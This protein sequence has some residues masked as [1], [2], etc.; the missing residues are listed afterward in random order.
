MQ[1]AWAARLVGAQNRD[2][3]WIVCSRSSSRCPAHRGDLSAGRVSSRCSTAPLGLGSSSCQRRP[4]SARRAPSSTGWR[5]RG[6]SCAWLSLDE[7]DNDPVRFLRYLW[8]AIANV[9]ADGPSSLAGEAA[10]AD[11]PDVIGEVATILAE[12]PEPSLLVLDDYHH[13][14]AAEVQRAVSILLDRLP[15]QAHLVS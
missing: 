9:A 14:E 11:V 2:R 12:R 6:T 4:G 15:A 7:A 10:S 5:P 13:I 1:G 3:Q 8:A